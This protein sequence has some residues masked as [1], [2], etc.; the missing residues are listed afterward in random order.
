MAK[1]KPI[2]IEPALGG[3]KQYLYYKVFGCQWNYSGGSSA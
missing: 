1:K 2:K 3:I